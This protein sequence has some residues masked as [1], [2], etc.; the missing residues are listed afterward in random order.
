MAA[1]YGARL[2]QPWCR[3]V[4]RLWQ[5]WSYQAETTRD[6]R[7]DFLRGFCIFMMIVDH[8]AGPSW[9][10]TITGGNSFYVSA[11]EGFVFI[12]GLLLGI[13]YRPILEKQGFRAALKKVLL[14]AWKLYLLMIVLTIGFHYGSWAAG[15]AWPSPDELSRPLSFVW[16]VLTFGRTFF[17]TDI[18]VMYTLLLVGAPIAFWMLRHGST[19]LLLICSWSLWG[20]YQVNPE[21]ASQPLTTINAF[22]PAAWQIFFVNA[23]VLG[24]HR[25]RVTE[26]LSGLHW[27][28]FVISGGLFLTLLVVYLTQG[29]VFNIF[30]EEEVF[31]H[32]WL[33][34][35]TVKDSLR[36]GRIIAALAVFPFAY[37]LLTYLWKPL[38]TIGSWL[39]M[40]LGQHSLYAY[41]MHV[42]LL[43]FDNLVLPDSVGMTFAGQ[44]VNAFAQLVGVFMIWFLIKR[45]FLFSVV[46]Q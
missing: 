4:W 27:S 39:I 45:R 10:H 29:G 23:M 3:Q 42:P 11:A 6:L 9:L 26:V 12:S 40:P 1:E 5:T 38:S 17:I 35:M 25:K 14:R 31:M 8:I 46:P 44:S 36:P 7:L 13:V 21:L 18:L 37:L 15:I 43:I 28:I 33:T 32:P 41:T 16:S 24:Y 34:E 30:F 19:W 2:T 22:H 20:L